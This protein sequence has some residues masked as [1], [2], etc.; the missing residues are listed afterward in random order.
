MCGHDPEPRRDEERDPAD[1][2][3]VRDREAHDGRA[4]A[5]HRETRR[6][7]HDRL[8]LLGRGLREA[9]ERGEDMPGE[10]LA[11]PGRR[12]RGDVLA[13]PARP[14]RIIPDVFPGLSWTR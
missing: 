6:A 1:R 11:P 9:R 14:A 12:R 4:T 13:G 2:R 3:D 5:A 7:L 10:A 8:A